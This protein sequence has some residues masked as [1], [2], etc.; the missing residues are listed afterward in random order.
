MILAHPRNLCKRP[1]SIN[2]LSSINT[3]TILHSSQSKQPSITFH[4]TNS[5]AFRRTQTQKEMKYFLKTLFLL[6][7]LMALAITLSATSSSES[8]EPTSL[9][10]TS[11]FH[12][13]KDGR[14]VLKCDKYPKICY[15]KGSAGPD[16]CKNKC[17]NF[18]TDSFNCGRCGKKCSF[19]KMCC[20]GKCV[21]P[22]TNKKHC[23]KCGNKCNTG[24]SC[25]YGMCSYA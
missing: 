5:S 1:Y 10:G 12:S 15:I 13:Q 6:A 11:R 21:N 4:S 25:V 18:S 9:R 14:V 8:E 2:S 22:R 20:E 16:C 19:G 17:V 24:G 3:S 23:G 7:M